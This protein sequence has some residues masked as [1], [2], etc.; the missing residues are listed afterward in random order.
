MAKHCVNWKKVVFENVVGE[1]FL[2]EVP[3]WIEH[4]YR[5]ALLT[6]I[7]NMPKKKPIDFDDAVRMAGRNFFDKPIGH[8]HGQN[9]WYL[10]HF[11]EWISELGFHIE[12]TGDEFE[13][14]IMSE[15]VA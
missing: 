2:A 10:E 12:L 15:K 8:G 13:P 4:Y 3:V 11:V 14:L 5:G 1:N 9:S 6:A 7:L